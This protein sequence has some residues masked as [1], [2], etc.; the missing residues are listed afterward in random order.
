VSQALELAYQRLSGGEEGRRAHAYNDATGA[1][2]SC[3]P[4]GN[5]TIAVGVDLEVGLDDEE[6]DWLSRHRL[7]KVEAGLLVYSWYQH[8]DPVRQSV[9]LDIAFNV[10][11]AGLLHFVHMIAAIGCADWKAAQ[12]ECS[13]QDEKLRPRYARLGRILLTGEA[14]T[15]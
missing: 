13:V 6:I 14:G 2:V 10:G 7:A 8:C 4:S 12:A 9:L 1:R 5:L 3:L 11:V 15:P